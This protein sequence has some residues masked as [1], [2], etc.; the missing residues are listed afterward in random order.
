MRVGRDR[1]GRIELQ[2]REPAHGLEQVRGAGGVQELGPD[3]DPS[4]LLLRQLVHGHGQTLGAG[5]DTANEVPVVTAPEPS[6]TRHVLEPGR[7]RPS[8]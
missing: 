7:I 4:R 8:S 6:M 2:E 1:G 5:P 3:G